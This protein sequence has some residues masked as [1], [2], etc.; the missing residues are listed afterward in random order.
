MIDL[1]GPNVNI[2]HLINSF[3]S[4][5]MEGPNLKTSNSLSGITG[6]HKK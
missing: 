6:R 1:W 5:I 4:S 3:G 2:H